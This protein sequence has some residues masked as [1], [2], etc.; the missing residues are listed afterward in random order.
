[1]TGRLE[2]ELKIA[3]EIEHSN[4][5]LGGLNGS[6]HLTARDGKVPS[7]RLN[8]NLMS[9]PPRRIIRYLQKGSSG[10]SR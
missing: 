8:A 1:M 4:H 7:L 10:Y 6:G 5:P 2:G 3:G 9:A